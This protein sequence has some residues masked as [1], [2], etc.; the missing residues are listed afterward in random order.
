MISYVKFNKLRHK[1]IEDFIK[2]NK[3]KLK[4]KNYDLE[5]I[6]VRYLWI[7]L[8]N[9]ENFYNIFNKKNEKYQIITCEDEIEYSFFKYLNKKHNLKKKIVKKK[10]IFFSII[11]Y[12]KSYDIIIFILNLLKVNKVK[13]N[14]K[15]IDVLVYTNSERKFNLFYRIAK[16][17]P[18]LNFGVVRDI[19]KYQENN[20]DNIF[21][22][23]KKNFFNFEKNMNFNSVEYKF[24]NLFNVYENIIKFYKPKIIIVIEGDSVVHSVLAEI[25]KISAIK[26]YCLEWGLGPP[27]LNFNNYDKFDFKN[28]FKKYIFLSWGK[29]VVKYLNLRNQIKNYK[30]I[31]NPNFSFNLKKNSSKDILFAL[32]PIYE[33]L[34]HSEDDI[35]KLLQFAN[36]VGKR[37][38]KKR[39][40]VRP[41]NHMNQKYLSLIKNN[42]GNLN[43]II[44]NKF[45]DDFKKILDNVSIVCTI[46][47]TLAYECISFGKIPFY[48]N[49]YPNVRKNYKEIIEKKLGIFCN[50]YTSAKK[51]IIDLLSNTKTFNNL[52][53]NI[54]KRKKDYILC[55]GNDSINLLKKEIIKNF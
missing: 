12:I 17:C 8:T 44:I 11:S 20:K 37:F 40:Y 43:N 52:K 54:N 27:Y 36:W 34:W 55:S 38:P 46:S 23:N 24:S 3:K 10:N 41:H 42:T 35:K 29:K 16:K 53:K 6:L 31:G 30:I 39:I 49:C 19:E 5:D 9:T 32:G 45:D 21:F 2:I 4:Y 22:I 33:F 7:R 15:D 25:A 1:A 48:I 26:I 51:K 47:S 28:Y 18:K 50:D 14:F 13:S